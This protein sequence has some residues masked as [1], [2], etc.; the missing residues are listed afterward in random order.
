[1]SESRPVRLGGAPSWEQAWPQD[2]LEQVPVCPACGSGASGLLHQGLV[3]GSF[4]SAAGR[5]TMWRCEA[6]G[7]GYLNPRPTPTSIHEAYRSYYTHQAAV[8]VA[9][10][11]APTGFQ[12]LRLGLAHGYMRERYGLQREPA[13]RYGA[14]AAALMPGKRE[15]LDHIC[16]HLP[17]PLPGA[18]LLDVGCGSGS[19]L[20]TARQ[21][22][23]QVLGVEP[24]PKAAS[25]AAALELEVLTGDIQVLA[26]R[27]HVFDAITLSHVIEHVHEPRAVLKD[28]FRLLR[29]GGL[30]WLETP[31]VDSR[32]HRLFGTQWRGLESPRHLVLFSRRGLQ[33]ALEEAGFKGIQPQAAP[34]PLLWMARQSEAMS[35][36]LMPGAPVHL[37]W[38]L[39]LQVVWAAFRH[40][41]GMDAADTEFFTWTAQK[42]AG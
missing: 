2:K 8:R 9:E 42:P 19:F 6:C 25:Q 38:R 3:D 21:C 5:W 13:S 31:N 12:R 32:G 23:W 41:A 16:R 15:A 26:D 10:E 36:G 27:A 20:L 4:R 37:S 34:N 17:K 40:R 11:Q 14:W 22:G 18:T 24:D 7:A 33:G 30:L 28:C 39:R 29:P 1:M 35:Q